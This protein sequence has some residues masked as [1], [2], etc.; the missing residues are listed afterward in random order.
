LRKFEIK[1]PKKTTF[2][3]R[4]LVKIEFKNLLYF[5]V[6]KSRHVRRVLKS[7]K[8]I[9][10]QEHSGLILFAPASSPPAHPPRIVGN[11]ALL[12]LRSSSPVVDFW[13]KSI[14]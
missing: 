6:E 10:T 8:I 12:D 3:L 14:G 1:N 11:E 13:C 5:I 2:I 7:K 9:L 4:I